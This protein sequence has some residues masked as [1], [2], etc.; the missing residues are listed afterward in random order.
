[1]SWRRS[2]AVSLTVTAL[3]AITGP[4]GDAAQPIERIQSS[5]FVRH[6]AETTCCTPASA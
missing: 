3:F 5:L 4:S 6:G 2:T 1:M